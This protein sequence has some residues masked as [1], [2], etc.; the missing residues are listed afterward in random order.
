M[1]CTTSTPASTKSIGKLDVDRRE[2]A[3]FRPFIS[4]VRM[5]L[6]PTGPP[7]SVSHINDAEAGETPPVATIARS[8]GIE[9]HRGRLSADVLRASG[10]AAPLRPP[11]TAVGFGFSRVGLIY[12]MRR[13]ER[14]HDAL[15]PPGVRS[16]STLRY[17]TQVDAFV[18]QSTD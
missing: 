17:S 7:C 13:S 12:A 16:P 8:R 10:S 3:H 4:R 6:L 2:S 5:A 9:V 18:P 15:D 11:V 14:L 1:L